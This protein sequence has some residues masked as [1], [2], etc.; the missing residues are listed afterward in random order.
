VEDEGGDPEHV[1][2][3]RGVETPAKKKAKGDVL[4]V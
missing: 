1:D 2:I 4:I 3:Q